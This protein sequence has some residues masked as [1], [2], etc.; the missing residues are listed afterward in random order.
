MGKVLGADL[1]LTISPQ[2]LHESS[3]TQKLRLGTRWVRG[4]R[5]FRYAKAGAALIVHR[6]AAYYD[7]GVSGWAVVPTATPAGSTKVYAT[8]G[9]S[10]GVAGN[11]EVAK[12]ELEGAWVVIFRLKAGAHNTD[13]IFQIVDNTA[14]AA[15]GGTCTLTISSELPY[16]CSTSAYTEI[17]GNIYS[18]VR[19]IAGGNR[20]FVGQPMIDAAANTYLWLQTWGPTWLNPEGTPGND[21]NNNQLVAHGNGS[22]VIHNAA[23]ATT[24]GKQH[25]GTVITRI[26]G[27]AE[28][29]GTPLI[30]LQICP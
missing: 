29:Q 15:G 28:T 2:A 23:N 26:A 21:A 8:I 10:E 6:L 20:M 11:G 16:E 18:D 13:Y 24:L 19:M 1:G 17:T 5:V 3:T 14:V 7:Y 4:D 12:H 25:V 27:G 22:V 9:S 30:M